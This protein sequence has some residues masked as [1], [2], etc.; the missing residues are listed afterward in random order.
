MLMRTNEQALVENVTMERS[1]QSLV[2][3]IFFVA[4]LRLCSHVYISY[5]YII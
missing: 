4:L 2:S 1:R 3:M 5:I